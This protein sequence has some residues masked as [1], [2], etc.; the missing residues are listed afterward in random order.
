MDSF[1]KKVTN[2]FIFKLLERIG[3]KGIYFFI[4]IIL[5]RMIIP[6]E[7]GIVSLVM[8]FI[9][10]CDVFVSYGFG[11]SLIVN[12][13]SDDLDF[14]TCLIFGIFLSGIVFCLFLWG[15]DVISSFFDKYNQ[16]ILSKLIKVMALRIPI[17]A[18][19]TVQ[20]AYIRKYMLFKKFFFVSIIATVISGVLAIYMA[21][22]GFGVW[23]LVMQYLGSVIIDTVLIFFIIE[24]RPSFQFSF[25]RL[26]I[27]YNYGWKVILV[28]FLD[29]GYAQLRSLVIGKKYSPSDLAYYSK[30]TTISRTSVSVFEET[31]S[32]VLFPALSNCN[33]NNAL[34]CKATK[35]VLKV[36]TFLIFPIVVGIAAVG[37]DFIS[38]LLTDI[39]LPSLPFLQIGCVAFIFRPVQIINSCVISASGNGKLLLKTDIINKAIGVGLLIF[40]IPFG[41][42]GIAIS[43]SLTNIISTCINIHYNKSIIN[44]NIISQIKD[45]SK[46]LFSAIIMGVVVILFS[47][48]LNSII[49]IKISIKLFFEILV[50]IVVYIS[51]SFFLRNESFGYLILIIKK[52]NSNVSNDSS[53]I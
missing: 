39:W 11:S 3:A 15:S 16:E 53:S 41:I 25:N 18:I 5:A 21:F 29:T 36:S 22:R 19:N 33:D 34:M 40:S 32:E 44:Y 28:A 49:S 35:K 42:K 9:E 26:K 10:I 6:H 31:L 4:S 47:R 50:G 27:I 13:K 46:S 14:S 8:I 23:A 37:K 17:A 2:G 38:L 12:R 52:R 20:H 24:W 51:L 48:F 7:Y 43:Y 1:E 30:G 45:I